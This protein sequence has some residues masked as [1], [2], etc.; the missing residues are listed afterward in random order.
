MLKEPSGDLHFLKTSDTEREKSRT[1]VIL[2]N[3]V[4]CLQEEIKW[5]SI[6][7]IINNTNE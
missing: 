5:K 7:K 3:H 1:I 4:K 6:I 2:L